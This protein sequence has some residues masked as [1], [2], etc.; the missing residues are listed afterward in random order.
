M[1]AGESAVCP[2]LALVAWATAHRDKI[3]CPAGLYSEAGALAGACAGMSPV[4]TARTAGESS[5]EPPA[6]QKPP[7]P[8]AIAVSIREAAEMVGV[9]L[10]TLMREIHRGNLRGLKVGRMWRVRIVELESYLRK[11]EERQARR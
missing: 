10:K 9:S 6:F 5:P 3:K 4:R 1:K 8:K 7:K 11:S 2:F